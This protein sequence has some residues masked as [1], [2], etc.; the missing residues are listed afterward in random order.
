MKTK[1]FNEINVVEAAVFFTRSLNKFKGNI[2]ANSAKEYLD[3]L[4]KKPIKITKSVKKQ[5]VKLYLMYTDLYPSLMKHFKKVSLKEFFSN[6]E[7]AEIFLMRIIRENVRTSSS[8]CPL[9]YDV[10]EKII[11]DKIVALNALAISL[12]SKSSVIV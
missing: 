1:L 6:K 9:S 5:L 3:Y 7:V 12:S 11:E 2:L 8:I 10:C 4:E